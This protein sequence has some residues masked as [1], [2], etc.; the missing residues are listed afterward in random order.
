MPELRL[1]ATNIVRAIKQLP[2]NIAYDY[3]SDKS[4]GQI[5]IVEIRGVSLSNAKSESISVQMI[6]RVANA[7][8]V[9]E[10][11]SIDRVLGASYNTRS[12][13]ETLLA[14]TPQFY[15]CYPGRVD[16]ASSKVK[17]GHKH[18]VWYPEDPHDN[19][20]L[21]ERATDIVIS[22]V[23]FGEA[24]YDALSIVSESGLGIEI[25]RRHTQIQIALITIGIQLGFKTWIAQNDKGIIYNNR[26]I[27]ELE[28]VIAS[29]EDIKFLS[30]MEE[31]IR[32]AL[33]I[34][35]VWFK[36]GRL[37]PAVLEVEHST[38]V[39]SGL[40]RMKN[41]QDTL[42]PIQTR[43]VIVAHEDERNKVFKEANKPQFKSL[44]TRFFPYSAVEELYVLCKKR[45]LRGVTEEFLDCFMEPVVE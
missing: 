36:N 42:P 13:L 3:I 20:I 23:S 26:R 45:Q 40:S 37:M 11:L 8:R 34:D 29:L 30:N 31:A 7:F 28:G 21:Q 35:C 24:V 1:T 5:Q 14:Y 44:N 18:L 17:R 43:Y 16:P 25:D 12:V 32:A 39:T 2:K 19:G 15:F 22:E 41:F 10:P 6:K 33:M 4:R 9:H 38:S 27:V